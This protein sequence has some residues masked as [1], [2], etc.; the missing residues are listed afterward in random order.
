MHE[1]GKTRLLAE[2]LALA[3]ADLPAA[4]RRAQHGTGLA[5]QQGTAVRTLE[6]EMR[7]TC[8]DTPAPPRRRNRDCRCWKRC[9][10]RELT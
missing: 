6:A 8:L 3:E 1:R 9:A 2:A 4:A 10:G 7:L 5:A